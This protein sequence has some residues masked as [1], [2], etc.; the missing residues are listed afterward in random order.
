MKVICSPRHIAIVF[1]KSDI[2]LDKYADSGIDK[3][4]RARDPI[5]KRA[6]ISFPGQRVDPDI[7]TIFAVDLGTALRLAGELDS[8]LRYRS[9][10]A[11]LYF[12]P[13]EE[14]KPQVIKR[15]RQG[16]PPQFIV[17]DTWEIE[18]IEE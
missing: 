17:P 6:E 4:G 10:L 8:I 12:Y 3:F 16:E 11:R 15:E 7:A 9:D 13:V 14:G 18:R 2:V 1:P 5:M